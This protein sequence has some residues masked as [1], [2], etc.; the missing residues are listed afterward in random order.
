M[1]QLAPVT[2][3]PIQTAEIK[4]VVFDFGLRELEEDETISNILG[5]TCR[6]YLGGP[7]ADP[8]EVIVG[9]PSVVGRTVVQEVGYRQYGTT[10]LLQC[11]IQGSTGLRHTLSA[12][13]PQVSA[14]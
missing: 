13:L 2:I 11:T 9:D 3:G 10:Y 4:A 12:L 8:D 1:T 5:V 6:R 14:A 7:D